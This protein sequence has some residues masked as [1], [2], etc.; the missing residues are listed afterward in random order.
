MKIINMNKLLTDKLKDIKDAGVSVEFCRR[1]EDYILT[2]DDTR[3]FSISPYR[4]AKIWSMDKQDVLNGFLFSSKAGIFDMEWNV[5]C[6]S[7]RSSTESTKTLKELT[8]KAHCEHCQIDISA[9]FDDAV[10]ITFNINQNIRSTKDIASHEIVMSWSDFDESLT[11]NVD[12]GEISEIRMEL[13]NGTY[14]MFNHQEFTG[15]PLKISDDGKDEFFIDFIY[16]D[17]K[18]KKVKKHGFK[19]GKKVIR[20]ENK[21]SSPI[22]I[23]FSKSVD[24]PWVSGADIASNQLFRDYFSTE[25]ISSDE[26]FSIKNIVFVFTDIKGSTDLYEKRGDSKAYY[27]VKE[28]FKIMNRIVAKHNGAIVKT[29]GDAVMATFLS[30]SDSIKAVFEMQKEFETF[31]SNEDSRDDI[32]IKIGMNRGSCLA[33]TS[34]DKLDY[35]GRTVNIAAR[36]QGLS[37]GNDIMISN[38][39]YTE[40]GI[41]D[42]VDSY[43]WNKKEIEATLKG[44]DGLYKVMHIYR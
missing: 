11:L 19:S 32:I 5:K 17:Q 18:I 30:S 26:M 35:F 8:S 41:A 4:L 14:F 27:L 37:G 9:G 3:L 13:D 1:I 43:S 36:V 28:H 6:P 42:I 31:N 25:L 2:A 38:T 12:A 24:F 34:N 29:I 44:I 15:S 20:I 10:E 7:C 33:V 21:S 23:A 22:E 39:L 16:E 40:Y